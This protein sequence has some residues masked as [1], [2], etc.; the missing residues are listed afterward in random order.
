MLKFILP[1]LWEWLLLSERPSPVNSLFVRSGFLV[2]PVYGSPSSP[3]PYKFLVVSPITPTFFSCSVSH[4]LLFRSRYYLQV[5]RSS[6]YLSWDVLYLLVT[7]QNLS[8]PYSRLYENFLI[9]SKT[10]LTSDVYSFP[11]TN[12][13]IISLSSQ[14]SLIQTTS[15]SPTPFFTNL[16]SIL[17]FHLDCPELLPNLYLMFSSPPYFPR[18]GSCLY[19]SF[20]SW[21]Y[22]FQHLTRP[23][24]F[25]SPRR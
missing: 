19:S 15:S 24:N 8:L 25:S 7:S 10:Q 14:L 18:Q 3:K 13:Q 17:N 16:R 22:L 23:K 5:S 1:V 9:T 11:E 4:S 2:D 6:S 20:D 21:H 12:L